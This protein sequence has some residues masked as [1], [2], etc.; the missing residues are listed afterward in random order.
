MSM[1][2]SASFAGGQRANFRPFAQA[3]HSQQFQGSSAAAM[4]QAGKN[5]CYKY[6]MQ[7]TNLL[8]IRYSQELT[9]RGLIF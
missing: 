8:E 1:P 7:N 3:G 5:H 9:K 2:M 4:A 6:H